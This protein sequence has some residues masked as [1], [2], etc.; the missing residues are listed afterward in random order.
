MQFLKF[1]FIIPIRFYKLAISPL[2]P[3]ACRFTPSCSEYMQQAI[4]K[5][6][7][8]K[9]IRLGTKRIA[10]CHPWGGQ[11]YDPVP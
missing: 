10:R 3:H 4:N 8:A 6:G 7:I 2:I 9:G 5:H 11:G 1:L